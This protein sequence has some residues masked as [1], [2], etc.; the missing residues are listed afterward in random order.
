MGK[1]MLPN[2][3]WILQEQVLL[4]VEK[5]FNYPFSPKQI[6]YVEMQRSHVPIEEG[7]HEVD[8]FASWFGPNTFKPPPIIIGTW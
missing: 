3:S 2:H 7:L 8:E 4:Q 5:D 1:N 6:Y